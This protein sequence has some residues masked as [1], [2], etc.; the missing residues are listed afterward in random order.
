MEAVK[1][2]INQFKLYKS[3]ES[4]QIVPS[5]LQIGIQILLPTLVLVFRASTALGYLQK[6][7][8]EVEVVSMPKAGNRDPGQPSTYRPIRLTS[9]LLKKP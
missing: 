7:W 1:W 3:P 9:F 4:D 8:R 6:A 5:M 2:V